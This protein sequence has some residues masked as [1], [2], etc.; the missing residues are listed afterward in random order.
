MRPLCLTM[1]AFGPYAAVQKLDFM[2][3]QDRT[4]FLIHGPTGAGKTTIL[5]G[6]CFALYGDASGAQRDGKSMR[7]DHADGIIITE[8]IF[9]FAIGEARYQV[10]RVPEQE[11]PKKRGEGT[12]TMIAQAELWS[13]PLVGEPTLIAAKWLDVTRH[14]EMILGFKSSQFRQ[15]VLLPQGEFRKLLTANSS[16]RQEI[17]QALFKTDL[18]RSIEEKLKDNASQLKKINDELTKQRQW[19]LQEADV[20][21]ESDLLESLQQNQKAI[22]NIALQIKSVSEELKEAQQAVSQGMVIQEKI[23]EK[24]S[25]Q[26]LLAELTEDKLIID[27]ERVE[28]VRATGALGL[29][30]AEKN[31]DKLA[32][33]VFELEEKIKIHRANVEL[34]IEQQNKLQ[35]EFEI[36]AAKEEERTKAAHNIIH[37]QQLQNKIILLQESLE[38][39][40]LRQ[41]EMRQ[42]VKEKQ[43]AELACTQ[44]QQNI[45]NLQAK[46]QQ[47]MQIAS[48]ASALEA[49]WLEAQR[50]LTKRK[51]LEDNRQAFAK[52]RQQ[53]GIAAA[54]LS[55]LDK[56]VEAA[57]SSFLQLQHDWAQGQS[58]LMASKLVPG[59]SCPVCGST[60]HPK[61]AKPIGNVPDESQIKRAQLQVEAMEKKREKCRTEWSSL[62]TEWNTWGKRI[63][64][65]VEELQGQAEIPLMELTQRAHSMQEQYERAMAADR[66]VKE[67]A[68]QLEKWMAEQTQYNKKLEQVEE[69]W[70]QTDILCKAA[71]AVVQERKMAIPEEFQEKGKSAAALQSAERTSQ[72]YKIA[73]EQ[74]QYNVQQGKQLLIKNQTILENTQ[75]RLT[76]SKQHY[77]KEQQHFSERVASAGFMDKEDYKNAK[78]S[79]AVMQLAAEKI[80]AFDREFNEAS[81]RL[82]QA[83]KAAANLVLPD[84]AQL[85]QV[86]EEMQQR[87]NEVFAAHTNL[88]AQIKRQQAWLKK[89]Q[90]LNEKLGTLEAQ[91]AVMGRLAEVA[92]GGNEHKLT[93][94]RFVLGTLLENVTVAANERLKMMSRNRYYLQ[95]T[96]DRVRKNAA[97]GLD[98]EVFDN[99]T[100]IAR[101][102]GTLSGG[103]TFLA[104]LSLA[105]GLADVVQSYSGGIHLDTILVDEGFGTLDPESLDFAV[106]ALIDLQQGGRLV[107]IISH[108]PELKERIDARLEV[109]TTERGSKACFKIG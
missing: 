21:Q 86:A 9:D 31:V 80:A 29:F 18:Y 50:V 45:D 92:N 100:G 90:Q 98:L 24:Q 3:L 104:S 68:E 81:M 93:L 56:E 5:D 19:V 84:M 33:D 96:F 109:M 42:A 4:F 6:M 91:Y 85:Q 11:R 74:A 37:L 62:Q 7:S 54:Q 44:G 2:E 38:T 83:A 46:Q 35:Q 76:D 20:V 78:K 67:V 23:K 60:E 27:E 52:V 41:A 34:G 63:T 94:Q 79:Q 12:T 58:A 40:T 105:L 107:G 17:M 64:D 69:I 59:G 28:L 51:L 99:Y 55:D 103:E 65:L 32:Q 66:K 73:W 49:Q 25:V 30:D 48:Q 95:R 47:Y 87:Y 13:I 82:E 106:K 26:Q 15:V 77:E 72:Q 70:R 36:E 75:S 88:D 89:T 8:V 102:V 1:T 22:E 10:K 53:V 16:E 97:G 57:K 71:E 14:I 39:V 108:V 61:P 101:G 43:K